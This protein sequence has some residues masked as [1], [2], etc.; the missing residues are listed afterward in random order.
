MNQSAKIQSS[1]GIS[2]RSEP[3]NGSSSESPQTVREKSKSSDEI[4]FVDDSI[5]KRKESIKEKFLNEG[6]EIYRRGELL[7][8]CYFYGNDM[9]SSMMMPMISLLYLI[10]LIL[11]NFHIYLAVLKKH[12][13]NLDL[14]HKCKKKHALNC[15]STHHKFINM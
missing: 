11:Y 6:N 5:A 4:P 7:L 3:S 2:E 9:D 1:D 15:G 12:E 13:M 14:R 8:C 10:L